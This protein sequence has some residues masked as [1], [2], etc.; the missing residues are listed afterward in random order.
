MWTE[1]LLIR[2]RWRLFWIE[3]D[4]KNSTRI[5]WYLVYKSKFYWGFYWSHLIYISYLFFTYFGYIYIFPSKTKAYHT[6]SFVLESE[7]IRMTYLR[8]MIIPSSNVITS[9][10]LYMNVYFIYIFNS[11]IYCVV[12]RTLCYY[13]CF[14]K[15]VNVN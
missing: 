3:I 5:L 12:F 4:K 11:V 10:L 7:L 14:F 15:Y 6:Y 2:E 1:I 9:Y 13:I 8:E